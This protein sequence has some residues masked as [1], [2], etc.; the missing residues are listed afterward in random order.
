[1]DHQCTVTFAVL[2]LRSRAWSDV[3]T[4]TPRQ[5]PTMADLIERP[6]ELERGFQLTGPAVPDLK[7][8]P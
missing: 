1:M 6:A 4:S 5:E 2:P 8:Y 7:I 3:K